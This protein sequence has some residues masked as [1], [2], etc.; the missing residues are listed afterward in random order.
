MRCLL[1]YRRRDKQD[2]LTKE[3]IQAYFGNLKYFDPLG[4]VLSPES[5]DTEGIK[6]YYMD[7]IKHEFEVVDEP[8]RGRTILTFYFETGQN[9]KESSE[10]SNEKESG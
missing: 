8:P 4:A 9:E 1:F 7:Y 10:V 6:L 3:T 2:V 5:L